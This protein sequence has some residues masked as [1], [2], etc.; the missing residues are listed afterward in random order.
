MCFRYRNI[1]SIWS[2]YSTVSSFGTSVVTSQGPS[3]GGSSWARWGAL[4]SRTGTYGAIIAGS[5]AAY[6][7]RV[8]IADY[9]SKINKQTISQTWSNVS[10]TNISEGLSY[11]S[12]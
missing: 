6:A 2:L 3:T 4:A 12:R 5:A 10:T 9:L 11:V 1:S 7:N 8:E